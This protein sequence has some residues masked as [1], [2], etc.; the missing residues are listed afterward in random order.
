MEEDSK[1]DIV[2]SLTE[3]LGMCRVIIIMMN[4]RNKETNL[5]CA[6]R[7]IESKIIATINSLR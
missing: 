1:H 3:M 2:L 5:I 6:L 7:Y 4:D